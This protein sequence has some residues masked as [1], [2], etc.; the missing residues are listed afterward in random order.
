MS[1]VPTYH[2]APFIPPLQLCVPCSSLSPSP[3]QQNTPAPQDPAKLSAL[4]A[5][6]SSLAQDD[7]QLQ[8]VT[9]ELSSDV[10]QTV[11]T[12]REAEERAGSR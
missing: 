4:V 1:P 3:L 12:I 8:A 10:K 9:A 11:N 7:S 5:S 6:V 2:V